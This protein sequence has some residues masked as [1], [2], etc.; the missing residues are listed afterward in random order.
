MKHLSMIL[1]LMS[2]PAFFAPAFADSHKAK[3]TCSEECKSNCKKGNGAACNC[4]SC[5]CAKTGKC[6]SKD[7]ASCDGHAHE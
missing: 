7:G 6:G 2:A 5:D 4:Q 1:A 3:C